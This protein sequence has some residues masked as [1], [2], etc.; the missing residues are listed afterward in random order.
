MRKI[1]NIDSKFR[2]NVF[3]DLFKNRDSYLGS[4][5]AF[6]SKFSEERCIVFLDPDIGLEPQHPTLDH[7]LESEAKTI[8][9]DTKSGD[10]YVLYQHRFF[11]R[12]WVEL[13]RS[14]LARAIESPEQ[15]IKIAHGPQIAR[16]V[17][18]FYAQ[19]P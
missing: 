1:E 16:D 14:Q 10:V 11:D 7:V 5:K 6:L 15:S 17:V 12:N 4:V 2:V 9:E 18:F 8:W 19:K 13:K 3:G